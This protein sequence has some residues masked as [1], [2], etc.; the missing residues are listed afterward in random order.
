MRHIRRSVS[1]TS[2]VEPESLEVPG[3]VLEALCSVVVVVCVEL[4]GDGVTGGGDVLCPCHDGSTVSVLL[5][6]LS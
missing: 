4:E 5:A 3:E 2:E 1:H 6:V